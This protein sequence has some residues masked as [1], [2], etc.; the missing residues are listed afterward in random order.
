[1]E[2]SRPHRRHVRPGLSEADL[3]EQYDVPV[4]VGAGDGRTM[5]EVTP[6]EQARDVLDTLL[7]A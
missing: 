6:D 1:M 5:G 7:V 4:L 2:V 3:A